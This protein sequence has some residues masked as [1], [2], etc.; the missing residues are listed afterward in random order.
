LDFSRKAASQTWNKRKQFKPNPNLE[1]AKIS[2]QATTLK[3]A[4]SLHPTATRENIQTSG[5]HANLECAPS[6]QYRI[7]FGKGRAF[8]AEANPDLEHADT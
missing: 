7:Q 2:Q 1:H 3:H 4:R 8:R 5:P 6:F